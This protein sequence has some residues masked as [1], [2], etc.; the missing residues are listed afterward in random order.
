MANN[1]ERIFNSQFFLIFGALFFTSLVMYILMSP[2]TEYTINLGASV[3]IAG[4][5][6]GIYVIGGLVSLIYSGRALQK[7]GWR[8]TAYVFMGIH[9][10]ACL[11]YFLSST[12]EILLFARFVHGIGMGAAGAAIITI[13]SAMFPKN[14]FGEA[15][16]YFLLGTPLAVGIGPIIGNYL[17]GEV[18]A[19]S[20][21]VVA[22]VFALLAL[23]C[24][25][26]VKIKQPEEENTYDTR[27][28]YSGIEKF[29][30]MGAVPISVVAGLSGFG[31]IAIISFNGIYAG[32]FDLDSAFGLFFIIYSI[33]L[34]IARPMGGKIQDKFGN[35]PVSLVPIALQAIGV[36]LLA[37]YPSFVTVLICAVC[38][39]FGFGTFYSIANAI[40]S[41]NAPPERNSYAIATYLFFTDMTLGFGPALLGLFATTDNIVNVFLAS[42]I[43]TASAFPICIL[44]LKK[45]RL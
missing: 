15:M 25:F 12:V 30:E 4:L 42:A 43:I 22:A 38:S 27:H 10:L 41:K 5:A 7:W 9:L 29:F 8:M 34:I 39:G 35:W 40:V 32:Q 1:N 45:Q 3:S 14:R 6:S 33:I 16:G 13:G 36:F 26:F 44:V 31:Y 23:L 24:I 37:V 19:E 28:K 17:I 20:C 18:S 2:I 21:F 11:L